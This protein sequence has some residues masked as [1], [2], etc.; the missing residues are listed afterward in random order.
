M[1]TNIWF[2]FQINSKKNS[3]VKD[4]QLFKGFLIH[5]SKLSSKV[6]YNY[7]LTAEDES[8]ISWIPGAT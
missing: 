6:V 3:W 2:F 4:Y 5:L 1:Y 8:L 7:I